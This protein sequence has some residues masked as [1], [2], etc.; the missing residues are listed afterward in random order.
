MTIRQAIAI[1]LSCILYGHV[2]T[3]Y[4]VFGV[5][6]VFLATF[7]KIFYGH[8]LRKMRAEKASIELQGDKGKSGS[9]SSSKV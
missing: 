7:F 5:A 3:A 2:I 4:G 8:K 1:L 6:V 9:S